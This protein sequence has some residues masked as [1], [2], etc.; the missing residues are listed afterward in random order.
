MPRL[1]SFMFW[2]IFLSMQKYEEFIKKVLYLEKERIIYKTKLSK[3]YIE[4]I[5]YT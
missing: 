5:N 4:N 2:Y 3:K 1:M